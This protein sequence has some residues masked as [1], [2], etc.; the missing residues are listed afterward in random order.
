MENF[1]K[2]SI[3]KAGVFVL[4]A[5]VFRQYKCS[6]Q[7]GNSKLSHNNKTFIEQACLVR[8][9]KIHVLVEFFSLQVYGKKELDQ[10]FPSMD[11]TS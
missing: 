7:S 11:R 9:G 8:T 5:H 1:C 3:I 4:V 2:T 6:T 10:Y